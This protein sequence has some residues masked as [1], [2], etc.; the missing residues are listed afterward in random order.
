MVDKFGESMSNVVI[1]TY[2]MLQKRAWATLREMVRRR[3]SRG[4]TSRDGAI[5]KVKESPDKLD[6]KGA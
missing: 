2:K 6:I 1:G 5:S 3:R 4:T